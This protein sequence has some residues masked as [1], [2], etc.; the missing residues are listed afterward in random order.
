[1]FSSS[2]RPMTSAS[3]PASACSSLSRWRVNSSTAG[4]QSRR[5]R[6]SRGSRCRRTGR[7]AVSPVGRVERQEE[8]QR[9]HRRDRE[10]AADRLWRRGRGLTR[11]SRPAGREDPVQAEVEAEDADRVR[12]VVAAAEPVVEREGLAVR[13]AEHRRVLR[14]LV[15]VE[16]DPAQAV[17]EGARVGRGARLVDRGAGERPRLAV[18]RQ[19]QDDLAEALVVE[20]LGDHERLREADA[21]CPRSARETSASANGIVTSVAATRAGAAVDDVGRPATCCCS[22]R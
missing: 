16:R 8:V 15:V 21:A 9:V 6:G 7:P 22:C 19:R 3:S 13:V 10:R 4:L 18:Q 12:D 2:L 1:M 20:V 5:P 11:C 17:G 14:A